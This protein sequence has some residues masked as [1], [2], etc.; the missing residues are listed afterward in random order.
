VP[1]APSIPW[2]AYRSIRQLRL[3]A[4]RLSRIGCHSLPGL[5]APFATLR[6]SR[7]CDLVNLL[8]PTA[9]R[10]VAYALAKLRF[11]RIS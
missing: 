11:A 6:P 10:G 9:A 5:A 1:H 4:A 3:C 2:R 7:P 8:I